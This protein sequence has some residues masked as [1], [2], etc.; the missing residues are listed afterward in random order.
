MIEVNLYKLFFYLNRIQVK[1]SSFLLSTYSRCLFLS[2]E[3]TFAFCIIVVVINPD[4]L[5]IFQVFVANPNKTHEIKIILAK[6]C[7][8]LLDLLRNLSVGK[9]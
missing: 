9:G 3:F 4:T 1:I 7:E 2:L 8:K 5:F 6:N